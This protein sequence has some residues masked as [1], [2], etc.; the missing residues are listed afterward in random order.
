MGEVQALIRMLRCRIVNPA[1]RAGGQ[2][3]VRD[4]C[5]P[6]KHPSPCDVLVTDMHWTGGPAGAVVR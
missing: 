5:S 4:R 2:G 1:A 6:R 3:F